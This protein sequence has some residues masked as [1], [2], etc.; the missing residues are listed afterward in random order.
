MSCRLQQPLVQ[1]L[2]PLFSIINRLSLKR[3]FDREFD[4][5]VLN[6]KGSVAGKTGL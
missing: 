2:P 1:P 4:L 5:S 6:V 3:N